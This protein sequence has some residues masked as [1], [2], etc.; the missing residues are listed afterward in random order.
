[1]SL[2]QNT[3]ITSA[4]FNTWLSESITEFKRRNRTATA[5]NWVAQTPQVTQYTTIDIPTDAITATDSDYVADSNIYQYILAKYKKINSDNFPANYDIDTDK[6]IQELDTL[7]GYLTLYKND[8]ATSTSSSD[9][10]CKANCTGLCVNSCSST[11]ATACD[12]NNCMGVCTAT[13]QTACDLNNCRGSCA[14]ACQQ[15][16]DAGNCSGQCTSG[17][18]HTCKGSCW[19]SCTATCQSMCDLGQC[20]ALCIASKCKSTSAK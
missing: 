3:T 8:P 16:C 15:G 1:M 12:A 18:Q 5:I 7:N 20:T 4:D 19:T 17:C 13:C 2:T 6:V 14:G 11:C 9:T 10:N